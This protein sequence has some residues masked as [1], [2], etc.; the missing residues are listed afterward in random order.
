MEL[1]VNG[2]EIVKRDTTGIL[3]RCLQYRFGS[4]LDDDAIH[5]ARMEWVVNV[6]IKTATIYGINQDIRR[7]RGSRP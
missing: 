4:S 5:L 6:G 2:S 3:S 1:N 7:A